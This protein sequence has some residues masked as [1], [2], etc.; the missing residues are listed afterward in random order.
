M[1]SPNLNNMIILGCV[2]TFIA[3]ML[4]GMDHGVVGV[5]NTVYVCEVSVFVEF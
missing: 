4:L 2:V 1:S 3:V 5:E